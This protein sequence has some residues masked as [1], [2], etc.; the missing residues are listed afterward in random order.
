MI[1]TMTGVSENAIS[2]FSIY[3]NPAKTIF[4]I[5]GLTEGQ[6][7]EI[8]DTTG[9]LVSS[10]TVTARN[11]FAIDVSS[12]ARGAYLVKVLDNSLTTTQKIIL[13]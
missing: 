5:D 3:P 1:P 11:V 2:V 8:R 7:I 4:Y 13:N 12:L 10:L 6:K 9:R